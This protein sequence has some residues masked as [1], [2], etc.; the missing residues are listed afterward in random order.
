MARTRRARQDRF[1]AFGNY[2]KRYMS[3]A[4][5]VTAAMPIGAAGVGAIPAYQSLERVLAA[6]ASLFCFLLFAYAFYIRESLG[7]ALFNRKNAFS[8]TARVIPLALIVFAIACGLGYLGVL[9]QSVQSARDIMLARGVNVVSMAD[10]L[11][12]TDYIDAPQAFTLIA[13]YLG[14]FV[15]SEAAFVLM[16]VREYLQDEL[17]LG[18]GDL[19]ILDKKGPAGHHAAEREDRDRS[20]HSHGEE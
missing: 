2:L 4:A 7:R 8:V 13:L 1:G 5:T 16:A 12:S 18:D 19:S 3:V 10:V 6:Y 14:L 9:Q 20:D 17:K 15:F 11:K